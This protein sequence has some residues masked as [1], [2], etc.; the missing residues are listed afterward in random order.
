MANLP[1]ASPTRTTRTKPRRTRSQSASCILMLTAA[2]PHAENG[3]RFIEFLLSAP[4]EAELAKSAAQMPLRPGV[5]VPSGVKR[6]E[7]I[8]AMT[9]D[10]EK[11]AARIDSLGQGFL[12]EWAAQ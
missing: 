5:P 12:K 6:V 7:E 10:Y 1:L 9:V 4:I 2:A 8:K 3:K 11:L